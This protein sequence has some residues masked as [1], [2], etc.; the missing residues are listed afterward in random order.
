MLPKQFKPIQ[1]F[2][3]IFYPLL[4][5]VQTRPMHQNFQQRLNI[6]LWKS[7]KA[8]D[9]PRNM[10]YTL[11]QMETSKSIPVF[12]PRERI[13]RVPSTG[14][15]LVSTLTRCPFVEKDAA[16]VTNWRQ[17]WSKRAVALHIRIWNNGKK[18]SLMQNNENIIKWFIWQ[19]CM[20]DFEK[21]LLALFAALYSLVLLAW[22]S[23]RMY[24]RMWA[25]EKCWRFWGK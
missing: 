23:R 21:V 15:Y 17:Y 9:E 25:I 24:L 13:L 22:M 6:F 7:S 3:N 10:I 16:R 20:H 1:L 12:G 18:I 19:D 8:E 2:T 11:D 4:L 5:K 14:P